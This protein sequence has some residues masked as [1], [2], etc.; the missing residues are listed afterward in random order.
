MTE[1]QAIEFIDNAGATNAQ[2]ICVNIDVSKVLESWH[3]SVFSFEWL[4][5][6]GSIKS[7]E[8]LSEDEK[9]KREEVEGTLKK[10]NSIIKPILGIGIQ[11]NIEIGTGRAVLL[12]LAALGVETMP[13]HIPKSNESDFQAFLADVN[14]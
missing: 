10:G 9:P 8:E 2:Y 1:R 14:S 13:V 12:T 4:K 5:S 11:D 6:D 3:L 7:L